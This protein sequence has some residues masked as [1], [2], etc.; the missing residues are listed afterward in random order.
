MSSKTINIT[1]PVDLVKKIDQA[2]K[3]QFATRSDY[4]RESLVHRLKNQRVVDEWDDASEWQTVANFQE[5]DPQGAPTAD[6]LAA[7]EKLINGRQN[8]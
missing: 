8:R 1:L 4:I 7:I 2:A 6:V 5:I 3:S